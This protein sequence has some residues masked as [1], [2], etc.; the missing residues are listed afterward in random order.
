[1]RSGY[2]QISAPLRPINLRYTEASSTFRCASHSASR[3]SQMRGKFLPGF[4]FC[5]AALTLALSLR[6]MAAA[7]QPP[8]PQA[9]AP[10]PAPSAQQPASVSR[11][12]PERIVVAAG[13]RVAV[14]LENGISTRSAK[15]GDSVYFHTN[16][17]I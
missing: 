7:Q 1:L 11:T 4:I 2:G 8:G 9:E 15:A 3:R 14:V 13:T 16:F 10:R 5:A 6:P 17:P 12:A